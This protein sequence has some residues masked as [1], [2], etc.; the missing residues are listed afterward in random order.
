MDTLKIG[1]LPSLFA[2]S[3]QMCLTVA[4][5]TAAYRLSSYLYIPDKEVSFEDVKSWAKGQTI[6]ISEG[7]RQFL[8]TI[9]CYF[10]G[11][12]PLWGLSP[13]SHRREA[14]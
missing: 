4:A 5:W 3:P 12:G 13:L 9:T 14:G 10:C 11:A 6:V 8:Y 2:S 1:R 7:C